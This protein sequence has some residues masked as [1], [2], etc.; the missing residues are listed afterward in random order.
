ME[1]LQHIAI[2][3]ISIGVI[4]KGADWLV[5]SSARMAKKLGV[6]EVV[7][8]LTIVAF[9]T[10]A[11]EFGVTIFAALS[12]NANIS[13][14]NIVGSNIFNLGFILGG[15]AIIHQLKT[16]PEL[17]KRDGV[18]LLLGT[19]LL[20][21]FLWDLELNWIEG[22]ILF[23]GLIF[24]LFVLYR[25]KVVPTDEVVEGEFRK[26]D[27][28]FLLIGLCSV[29]VGAHFMVDSAV[30]LARIFHISEWLIGATIVAA[31]TSAPEFA[32]SI[33]AA[34]K[35]RHGMSVGNLIG[36]DIFNILGVLGLAG[37]VNHLVIDSTA[38]WNMVMLIAMVGLVLFFMSRK[39]MVTRREGIVL[40][41]FGFLRWAISFL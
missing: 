9:G 15:T 13:V 31:G 5:E 40:V 7:I 24:Y 41:M 14:G 28:I 22:A 26:K 34:L 11:P 39:N 21:I 3:I 17:L 8:G 12:G 4:A 29:L 2:L 6:S 36:S 32:T 19:L 38:R 18:V 33:V 10:S 20:M 37:M 30:A 16:T 27:V 25:S 35:G 1:I 23:S